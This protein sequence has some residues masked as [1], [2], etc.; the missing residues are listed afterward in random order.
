VGWGGGGGEQWEG[1]CGQGSTPGVQQKHRRHSD[2]NTHMHIYTCT[3]PHHTLALQDRYFTGPSAGTGAPETHMPTAPAATSE[4]AAAAGGPQ[5]PHPPSSGSSS[6]VDA[7]FAELMAAGGQHAGPGFWLHWA[8][9]RLG[10]GQR[11]HTAQV[12]GTWCGAWRCS[13]LRVCV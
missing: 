11:L 7:H 8:C 10:Y 9:K 6:K 3:Y 5:P 2:L 4:A 13:C 1:G 12:C